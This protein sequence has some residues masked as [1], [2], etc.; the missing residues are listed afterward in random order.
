MYVHS[1]LLFPH[2]RAQ[3]YEDR[4]EHGERF[5]ELI[6]G[7]GSA[8]K[9]VVRMVAENDTVLPREQEL[10]LVRLLLAR[11]GTGVL[12]MHEVTEYSCVLLDS[13]SH[14]K[15]RT[16]FPC[17][18]GW[19]YRAHHLTLNL[20]PLNAA[21][22]AAVGAHV[23]LRVVGVGRSERAY[24]GAPLPTALTFAPS[25]RLSRSRRAQ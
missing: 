16:L 4:E 15:L 9:G 12:E 6:S 25:P 7:L 19:H 21:A 11:Y 5:R 13:A 10:E 3:I 24:A 1:P 20:G 8:I 14:G 2:T 23:S 18:P 17:P 22:G